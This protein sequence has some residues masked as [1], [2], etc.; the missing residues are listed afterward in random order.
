MSALAT[1]GTRRWR[2]AVALLT[3]YLVWGSTYL[4]IRFAIETL[5]T[6][7]M[8]GVRYLVAGGLLYALARWR[9]AARPAWREWRPATTIGALLLLGGNGGVVWA[10][11]RVASGLA[12]LLVATE[13]LWI[14]LLPM[15]SGGPRPGRRGLA[16][17]LL[18]VGGV[19]VLVAGGP[20][21]G[22]SGVDP[23]GAAVLVLASLSWAI[24]SLYAIAAPHPRSP[25]LG[26]GMQLL[27][28]GALLSLAGGL[29]GEWTSISP[30]GFSSRSL[31]ALA[32]L[33]VFGTL[34]AF[35]AYTW[36]LRHAAPTLVSTYAFVNPMVAVGLGWFFAGEH[37]GRSELLAAFLIVAAVAAIIFDRP[38]AAG[39]AEKAIDIETAVH[40]L[41]PETPPGTLRE[42]V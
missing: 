12:A 34:L 20:G 40:E 42:A 37:I 10:E 31:L 30:A 17:L 1:L 18:G 39:R 11:H 38:R 4:A 32:Y 41:P 33:V 28:G 8:A 9:G 26:T 14:A 6:F 7:S 16:G 25:L 29:A 3:V 35:T 24:G 23:W 19:A 36:L 22:A 15:L 27:S 13:P 5:P 2:I 21:I